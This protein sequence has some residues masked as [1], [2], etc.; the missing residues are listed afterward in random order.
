MHDVSFLFYCL[1]LAMALSCQIKAD[2]RLHF[3]RLAVLEEKG[4][5]DK[6]KA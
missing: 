1:P 6:V 5:A 2:N 3:Y 4:W